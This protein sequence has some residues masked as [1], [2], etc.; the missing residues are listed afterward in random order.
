MTTCR[1]HVLLSWPCSALSCLSINFPPLFSFVFLL[2]AGLLQSEIQLS[3]DSY[4]FTYDLFLFMPAHA[5]QRVCT[6]TYNGVPQRS[7]ER[8]G[9]HGAGDRRL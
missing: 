2:T 6:L 3:L 1:A 9:S 4:L 5:R 8:T 7:G